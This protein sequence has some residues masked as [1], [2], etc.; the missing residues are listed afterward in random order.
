MLLNLDIPVPK[1]MFRELWEACFLEENFVFLIAWIRVDIESGC[2]TSMLKRDAEEQHEFK[3]LNMRVR[4]AFFSCQR[5]MALRVSGDSLLVT[6]I[7]SIPFPFS[8]LLSFH[9]KAVP[10]S[11]DDSHCRY[12]QHLFQ[13]EVH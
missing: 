2:V 11:P 8:F 9:V 1:I 7:K 10:P 5:T 3:I 13:G 12:L 6:D 4:F